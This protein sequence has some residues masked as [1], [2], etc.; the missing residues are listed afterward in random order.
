MKIKKKLREALEKKVKE[1][2]GYDYG[3]VMI[4][5][6][7]NK[8]EWKSLQDVIK[9]EDLYFGKEDEDSSSYGREMDP[10]ATI[11]YGIH[12]DVP[13]EDVKI[14]IDEIDNP[15]MVFGKV[16]SFENEDFDV[17]KFDI[18]SK[19][20]TKLNK[21]FK[22]LPHTNKFPDY[23]PH[24]TTAFVKKGKAKGYIAKLNNCVKEMGGSNITPS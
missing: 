13:D 22:D 5:L 6:D 21:K 15:K 16:S 19:D 4:F 10:H 12:S 23:H 14:L 3:C 8:K 7:V 18:D 11:L 9:E 20:L 17:L 1:K 24:V 2:K